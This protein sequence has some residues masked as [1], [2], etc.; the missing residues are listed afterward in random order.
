VAEPTLVTGSAVTEKVVSTILSLSS[1]SR[2]QQRSNF[3]LIQTNDPATLFSGSPWT[4][5]IH[6]VSKIM[7]TPL[8][9]GHSFSEARRKEANA[10]NFRAT[11]NT[12]KA[13]LFRLSLFQALQ[14]LYPFILL[15]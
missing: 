7:A 14:A 12:I 8:P 10:A 4:H 15:T 11:S 6:Q 3:E 1:F 5:A 9:I 2:W 13:E